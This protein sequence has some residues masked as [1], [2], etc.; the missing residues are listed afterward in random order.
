MA[1]QHAGR[2]IKW[3]DVDGAFKRAAVV[4]DA[5]LV[6]QRV[7][8]FA[9]K[10]QKPT[11]WG[12]TQ[13]PHR[14]RDQIAERLK[15]KPEQVHLMTGRVGG[16]FGAKVPV[17]QEDT[18]VPMLARRLKRPVRWAASPREDMLATGHGRDMRCHLKLAAGATLMDYALP[19]TDNLISFD[20]GHTRTDSPRTT[21]GLKGIG[22]AATIG[23]TPAIANAVIDALTPLGV[24]HVD[25][26]LTAQKIW[27]AMRTAAKR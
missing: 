20:N 10:P 25:L 11:L 9:M 18:L 12:D 16:G 27:A 22:E 26:P 17:F 6:N 24:T 13:I 7:I 3:G 23:S 4:V 8:P 2:P 14:T 15:L 1:L 21:L 19:R 5:K